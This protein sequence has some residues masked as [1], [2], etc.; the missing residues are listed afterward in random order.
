MSFWRFVNQTGSN[1]EALLTREPPPTLEELL[2]DT[3][4][5]TECKT[6]NAKLIEILGREDHV[7][8]LLGWVTKNM[9]PLEDR[10][11]ESEEEEK[12]RQKFP[13]LAT[14]VLC[15]D[16]YS[17]L[18]TCLSDPAEY[19]TPF[20]EKAIGP[21]PIQASSSSSQ[22]VG[23]PSSVSSIVDVDLT[24]DGSQT[25]LSSSTIDH[26]PSPPPVEQ[27][28]VK[29]TLDEDTSMDIFVEDATDG[30]KAGEKN[31]RE[32]VYGMWCRVN[33]VF[34]GKKTAEILA[35]IKSQPRIIERLLGKLDSPAIVDLFFRLIQCEE[36]PEGHGVIDWLASERLVERLTSLLHPKHYPT[37]HDTATDLLK[38]IITMSAPAPGPF[39]PNLN[40]NPNSSQDGP[41]S[42]GGVATMKNNLLIRQLV[43]AQTVDK[44]VAYMFRPS[45]SE[46]PT[47]SPK[48]HK[49]SVASMRAIENELPGFP[50]VYPPCTDP[51]IALTSSLTS[52]IA[53]FIELIRKNNTD[54]S[55]PHLFHV[56][57]NAL[58]ARSSARAT[59]KTMSTDGAD[60]ENGT[61]DE[62]DDDAEEA[63]EQQD[64]EDTMERINKEIGIVHLGNLLNVFT[65]NIGGFQHL[66]NQP[67]TSNEAAPTTT[68]PSVPLTLERFRIIELYAEL[69]HC[70]NMV[71]LNRPAGSG[72]VYNENG[73]LLEGLAGLDKLSTALSRAENEGADD[74][75]IRDQ[76]QA[77]HELPISCSSSDAPLDID[78]EDDDDGD[79]HRPHIHDDEEEEG[80]LNDGKVGSEHDGNDK[81]D[82]L[83]DS[84]MLSPEPE[85]DANGEPSSTRPTIEEKTNGRPQS[86]DLSTQGPVPMDSSSAEETR[87]KDVLEEQLSPGDVLKQAFINHH[88]LAAL[89]DMFFAFPLNN[90]LHTVVYD[91]LQQVLS[92]KLDQ[93]LNKQLVISLFCDAQLIEK[94]LT[95]QKLND[96]SPTR[97]GFMGHLVLIAE[98]S[99]RFL[100]Q[101]PEDLLQTLT[102][103]FDQEAWLT[104][105]E[106][107]YSEAKKK[108]NM[109]MGGGKPVAAHLTDEAGTGEDTESDEDEEIG[110]SMNDRM[111]NGDA[112]TRL[113]FSQGFGF[114]SSNMEED[115]EGG[116]TAQQF[117]RYLAQQMTSG[118]SDRQFES[119]SDD[120]DDDDH[121]W[122]VDN[123]P[124][125]RNPSRSQAFSSNEPFV[126]A[127][128]G[129]DDDDE[130]WGSFQST[131]TGFSNNGGDDPFGDDFAAPTSSN[132]EALAALEW[133]DA[134]FQ[135]EFRDIDSEDEESTT[136]K[137]RIPDADD[138]EDEDDDVSN[139]ARGRSIAISNQAGS[140]GSGWNAFGSSF[141]RSPSGSPSSSTSSSSS[142]NN[143]RT[144]S[145]RAI[146]LNS[147]S[148]H[149]SSSPS[150]S[151]SFS[152]SS[153]N[154]LSHT[155]N[156]S[157]SS[158]PSTRLPAGA[159]AIFT[160]M[161]AISPPDPSLL[162]ATDIDRPLGPG[163]GKGVRRVSFG[164]GRSGGF[165]E[166]MGVDGKRIRVPQDEIALAVEFDSDGSSS[167]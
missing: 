104:F 56:V 72:P 145:P 161:S 21:V 91:V 65:E 28:T 120:D 110:D 32:I 111:G 94:I 68:G 66:I 93:G 132:S 26:P 45:G 7:K 146:A 70:S 167:S 60:D 74:R 108:D 147:G 141:S 162:E 55:E 137:I 89:V 135:R 101:C 2:E 117:S 23:S 96:A 102:S 3:E 48:K 150:N 144:V 1:F 41:M 112:G 51:E 59:D 127:G 20:W 123:H 61:L 13:N 154:L 84:K 75:S 114:D 77:S 98:D 42:E 97:L 71:I 63:R 10:V 12:R 80:R 62:H 81:V 67:R 82:E 9:D 15:S 35:F 116:E 34:L 54:Y 14:E 29:D 27:P 121:D 149:L 153:P 19:L 17:I 64:L 115:G 131:S 133:N 163:V 22:P 43:N 38:G 57:R 8:G 95:G 151:T 119:S 44:L 157:L 164:K 105:V 36:I 124:F 122:M 140:S 88:L 11:G 136:T 85:V 53:V 165:L 158:S 148:S 156:M 107:P 100:S 50:P 39:N 126:N 5:L 4:L 86:V 128:N 76:L 118:N 109:V 6:Q 92:G 46:T 99:I 78:D 69:L 152:P 31:E 87:K 160:P 159:A 142:Y 24:T 143:P 138:E 90:F 47:G 106:G 113:N 16:V 25:A 139:G 134:T 79:D 49:E 33:S 103:S 40:G 130:A 52:T 18:D 37:Y 129:F 30:S 58:M 83:R 73:H 166:K 155:T 125:D